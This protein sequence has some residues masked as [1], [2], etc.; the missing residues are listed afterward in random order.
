MTRSLRAR[1][2][3]LASLVLAFG[4]RPTEAQAYFIDVNATYLSDSSTVG[5]TSGAGS[6][7]FYDLAL[8]VSIDKK[9]GWLVGWNYAGYSTSSTTGSTTTTYSSTQMGPKFIVFFD[10]QRS[11]LLSFA[12]NL[13]TNASYSSG[14]GAGE[15]WRGTGLAGCLGYQFEIA[16]GMSLGLR[17]NYSSSS[18]NEKLV[19]TNYSTVS[20]SE[21]FIYPSISTMFSW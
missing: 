20:N 21:T 17:L 4:A 18:Y 11:W 14:S 8:G 7:L 2:A 3:A 15:T 6:K 16:S 9:G 12:Y 5:S 13:V 1:L 19:G 10:K